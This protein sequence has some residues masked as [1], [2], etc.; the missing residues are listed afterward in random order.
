[1]SKR[2]ATILPLPSKLL[3]SSAT[4]RKFVPNPDGPL[5]GSDVSLAFRVD[6]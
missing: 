4:S 5:V 2:S 6:D 3:I 1:M